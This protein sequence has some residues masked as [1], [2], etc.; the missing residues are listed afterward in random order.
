MFLTTG[1]DQWLTTE[2]N[3]SP[4]SNQ[5][6]VLQ[7]GGT[8]VCWPEEES[9]AGLTFQMLLALEHLSV[10]VLTLWDYKTEV[11]REEGQESAKET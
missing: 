6:G 1:G 3:G 10:S 11:L 7:S 9:S 4:A 2:I 5:Q 8:E